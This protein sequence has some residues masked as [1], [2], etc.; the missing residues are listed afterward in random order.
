MPS[1]CIPP[2]APGGIPRF[3][4]VVPVSSRGLTAGTCTGNP[5]S[6]A[7]REPYS[8]IAILRWQ[9]APQKKSRSRLGQNGHAACMCD[10]RHM[11]CE[12]CVTPCA[13]VHVH[14]YAIHAGF[15]RCHIQYGMLEEA[16]RNMS[17][18]EAARNNKIVL[19][20]SVSS[21]WI[22]KTAS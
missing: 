10:V 8:T 21:S 16:A 18:E 22:N 14:C 9:A 19:N 4:A 11:Q 2:R 20:Q 3:S 7:K 17:L 5:L 12:V 15:V 1:I 13:R 6:T